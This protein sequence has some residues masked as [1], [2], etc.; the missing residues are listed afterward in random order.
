[1]CGRVLG[2]V[3]LGMSEG[4]CMCAC[5]RVSECM[6]EGVCLCVSEGEHAYS[7]VSPSLG[8]LGNERPALS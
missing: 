1:M 4:D 2:C 7:H 3:W 8:S 5:P 6:L